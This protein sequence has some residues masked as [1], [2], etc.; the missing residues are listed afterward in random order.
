MSYK[1][2]MPTLLELRSLDATVAFCREMELGLIE[3]NMTRPEFLPSSLMRQCTYRTG[4]TTP[5]REGRCGS[6]TSTW[7]CICRGWGMH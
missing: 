1:I 6:T 2:G 7:I 4:S 5:C 3:L